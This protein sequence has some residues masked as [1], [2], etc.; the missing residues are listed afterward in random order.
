MADDQKTESCA[1]TY[2]TSK[3]SNTR[4]QLCDEF[5]MNIFYQLNSA[6]RRNVGDAMVNN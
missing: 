5:Y 2:K 6:V 3:V 4:L 1:C